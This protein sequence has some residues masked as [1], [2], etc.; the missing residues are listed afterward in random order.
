M[1]WDSAN[2]VP[3]ASNG[4]TDTVN[5]VCNPSNGD[6]D[7]SIGVRNPTNSVRNA[8]NG[9]RDPTNAMRNASNRVAPATNGVRD[10]SHRELRHRHL[11]RDLKPPC[12]GAKLLWGSEAIR[13]L[14][15]NRPEQR[16]IARH[17]GREHRAMR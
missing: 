4:V 10:N 9:F 16:W 17:S 1:A 8:S 15:R 11:A 14:T 7:A 13:R 6:R 5:R 3:D 12:A 2:R